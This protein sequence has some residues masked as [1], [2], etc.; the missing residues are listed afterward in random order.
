MLA[1]LMQEPWCFHPDQVAT[2]TDDQILHR[3]LQPAI[4]RSKAA[5]PGAI[6]PGRAPDAGV[7][8][9]PPGEPGSAAH[10]AA[11]ISAYMNVQGLSRDRAVQQYERQLAQYEAERT[12]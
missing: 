5:A 6:P 12:S 8:S 1:A 7:S 4:E 10:R 2:L 3:Y 9:G 11:C